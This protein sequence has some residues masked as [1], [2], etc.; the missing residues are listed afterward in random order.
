MAKPS[1]NETTTIGAPRSRIC[2]IVA[3]WRNNYAHLHKKQVWHKKNE[4]WLSILFELAD[5]PLAAVGLRCH[6]RRIDGPSKPEPTKMPPRFQT[7]PTGDIFAEIG[8]FFIRFSLFYKNGQSLY[9]NRLF[10]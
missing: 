2:W 6:I 4:T 3:P 5:A 10:A 8:T 1:G 7:S 9:S